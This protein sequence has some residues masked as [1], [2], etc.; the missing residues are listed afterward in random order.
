MHVKTVMVLWLLLLYAWFV[1]EQQLGNVFI[2][3]EMSSQ[4]LIYLAVL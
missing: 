3:K 4:V 2:A 1:K